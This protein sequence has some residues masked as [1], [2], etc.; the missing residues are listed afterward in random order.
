[1]NLRQ[2]DPDRRAAVAIDHITTDRKR[3]AMTNRRPSALSA[4]EA[5]VAVQFE[6]LVIWTAAQNLREGVPLTD[7]D[8]ARLNVAQQRIDAIVD[9]VA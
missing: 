1:M 7:E 3:W 4:R 6:C 2:V 8:M 5:L 9:E